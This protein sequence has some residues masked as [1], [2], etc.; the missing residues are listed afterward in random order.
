M[1][2]RRRAALVAA[3]LA[4]LATPWCS[5][6]GAQVPAG[7]RIVPIET[8]PPTAGV[9][10]ALGGQA[11]VTDAHGRGAIAV[12]GLGAVPE[13]LPAA[14]APAVRGVRLPD[15]GRVAFARRFGRQTLRLAMN[16][17]YRFEPSFISVSG[18]R[19][20]PRTIQSYTLKSRHGV[21]LTVH[22]AEP[23]ELQSSRVVSR[24]GALITKDVA[25]A[26]E[27][28][29]V[30]GTN[31]VNRGQQRFVP[32]KLE[33]PF[34]VRLLFYRARFTSRDAMFGSAAGT[35]IRLRY[36][37]GRVE[38]HELGADGSIELDALPRGEYRVSVAGAG[39]SPER[40]VALSRDQVVDLQLISYLDVAIIALAS[41]TL[42]LGLV[43]AR[44][45]HLRSRA[46]YKAW[47]DERSGAR[48]PPARDL[49]TP[50]RVVMIDERRPADRRR[51]PLEET[52]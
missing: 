10:V 13:R 37:S 28:V 9:R 34:P 46:A 20:E 39:F 41:A 36:P 4:V 1:P 38:E 42:A 17:Y 47:L 2:Q 43:V 49:V 16:T 45:P 23:V 29:M 6:A 21:T 19:I 8:V 18:R 40:P 14:L 52:T 35:A 25:W 27:R 48:R 44:R 30:D 12:S 50:A 51:E 33:G 31:V 11:I 32:G 5:A 26:V 15:G 3:V 7:E 22:G 24:S